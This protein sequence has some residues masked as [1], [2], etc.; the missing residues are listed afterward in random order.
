MEWSLDH[1]F[2]YNTGTGKKISLTEGTFDFN[3]SEDLSPEQDILGQKEKI[4]TKI[5][6]QLSTEAIPHIATRNMQGATFL[7]K[8]RTES[9][10]KSS[11]DHAF[12]VKDGKLVAKNTLSF[13]ADISSDQDINAATAVFEARASIAD[14]IAGAVITGLES[15]L[16]GKGRAKNNTSAQWSLKGSKV[17]QYEVAHK[18]AA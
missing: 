11:G 6:S 15:V 16:N 5:F 2:K 12:S 8:V 14:H 10:I 7:P 13:S 18:Q 1:D 9:R 17:D 4:R 3:F